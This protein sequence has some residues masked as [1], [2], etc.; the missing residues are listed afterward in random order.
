MIKKTLKWLGI[1]FLG[2]VLLIAIYVAL[3]FTY[4][5]RV[6]T[7]FGTEKVRNVDWY[8]PTVEMLPAPKVNQLDS[9]PND[10]DA[11][12]D[13]FA[14]ALEYAQK[15]NTS[16]FLV[17]QNGELIF[18]KYWDSYNK[19]SYT[20]THSIHKSLLAMVVGI[21]VEEGAISS[22]DDTASKYIGDWVDQSLGK[23]TVKNLLTMSSGLGKEP[24]KIFLLSHFVRLL[25]ETDISAVAQSL[26]QKVKPGTEFEYI[27]TNTQLL[28][29]VLESA[30]GQQYESYLYEKIWSKMAANP[31]YLWM[32]RKGGTPHG[33]CCLIAKPEDLLRIG[34]LI[35]NKGKVEGEQV[36]PEH[37]VEK[38]IQPSELNPNYGYGIWRGTPY[39][40]NRKY[41]PKS[42][43][44]V[45]HSEPYKA[46]DLI[47]FDG[48]GGQR[49]YI[50][51]SRE[52]II[53]R[54]GEVRMDFDDAILPNRVIEAIDADNDIIEK[55]SIETPYEINTI[56]STIET[57]HNEN[58]NVHVT[59]PVAATGDLPLIVFSHGNF[60][61]AE[62]YH[63]L[64]DNWVSQGY[65]VANPTHLDTGGFEAG[66]AAQKTY[67]SDWLTASRVLDMQA[68]ANQ[69]PSILIDANGFDGKVINSSYIA[70]GHSYG[71][72]SAQ[73]LG[74]ASLEVQGDSSRDIP[75]N[76]TDER[77]AAI[78]AI[79][80][81][82]TIKEKL[83]T[84]TWENLSTPQLV[85]TGTKDVLPPFWPDYEMHK[86]SYESAKPGN[87]YLLVLEDV[88]HYFGNLIGRL[89]NEAEPQQKALTDT[90]NISLRFIETYL[91]NNNNL[92]PTTFASLSLN[93][94]TKVVNFE[95][96]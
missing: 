30:T 71:A 8:Q 78:V 2:I 43:F 67:G 9:L 79:S 20:Q 44:S 62:A 59:Y 19:E 6:L 3:N 34:M 96:R 49:V 35:L 95:H 4:V 89:N 69:V 12:H 41:N 66:V 50:I 5:K 24:E 40:K 51:P 84:K 75:D 33:Y 27:N 29:D 37:W 16:A 63:Q 68:T 32:D 76:L 82:G 11:M 91:K 10:D 90:S 85:V 53:V 81:P 60:L 17:W 73:I 28:V 39:V 36:V 52:L 92:V 14:D 56:D 83:T 26:P 18:D 54:V 64:I 48:F 57:Q 80:P 46:D 23:I 13:K 93:D 74:G 21:A 15:I 38:A 87:N 94:Y 47:Y 72:L 58:L 70:A 88:D 1:I 45:L 31:G 65:V 25:N 22:I 42:H 77:V 61:S 7:S 55:K 86:I